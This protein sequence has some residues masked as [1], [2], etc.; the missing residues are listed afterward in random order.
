MTTITVCSGMTIAEA[1]HQLV[2]L[3]L[4]IYNNAENAQDD[5]IVVRPFKRDCSSGYHYVNNHQDRA[6]SVGNI[7]NT[8]N[9]SFRFNYGKV[10]DYDHT[11][12]EP[13]SVMHNNLPIAETH[14]CAIMILDWLIHGVER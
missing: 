4:E 14:R 3:H 10:R 12:A 11:T 7:Q 6:C 5:D 1:V 8:H 2:M 9:D 13:I